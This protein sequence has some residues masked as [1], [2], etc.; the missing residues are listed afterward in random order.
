[1]TIFN[2]DKAMDKPTV[3]TDVYMAEGAIVRGN[4]ELGD[5]VSIWFNAVVRTEQNPIKIGKCSNIQDNC[6]VHT[7]PWN[8]VTIG[9]YVTVGHGAILHGCTIGDGCLIG[10]GAIVMNDAVIGKNCIIGAGSLITEGTIIPDNSVVMGSPGKVKRELTNDDAAKL[11]LN[12]EHY[13]K[14]AAEY[15]S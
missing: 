8:Q 12:A 2:G 9:E 14:I 1:M 6:V 3:G 11:R 7:D 4:V 13:V 5:S 15:M 10:M